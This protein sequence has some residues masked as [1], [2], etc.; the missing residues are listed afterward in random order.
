MEAW[1]S[2]SILII[3][4]GYQPEYTRL[5]RKLH[6]F[7]PIPSSRGGWSDTGTPTKNIPIDRIIEDPFFKSSDQSYFIQLADFC[8]YSL[9]RRENPLASKTK[10][11]LDRAFTGLTPILVSQASRHDPEGIIRV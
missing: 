8:S 1:D 9:L 5:T 4:E 7:N 10:Y 3:D 2:R 6:V 11:G